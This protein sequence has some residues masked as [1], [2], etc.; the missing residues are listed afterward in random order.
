LL[1]L[2]LTLGSSCQSDAERARLAQVARLAEHIDR[3][4]R[5]DNS[6]KRAPLAAL[7]AADCHDDTSCAL[8]DLCVRAYELHQG[9]L[10]AINAL[11]RVAERDAAALE[12]ARANLEATER[13]LVRAK[14]LMEQCAEEQVRVVRKSLM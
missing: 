3:L 8:K 4:R 1:L 10:D 14:E 6:D 11:K 12:R 2:T 7:V 13:D 9:S 5:A